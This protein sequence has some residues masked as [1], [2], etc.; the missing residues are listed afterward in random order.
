MEQEIEI[1]IQYGEADIIE[2]LHLFLQFPELR[3]AF[4]E[5]ERKNTAPQMGKYRT[6]SSAHRKSER[7]VY[8]VGKQHSLNCCNL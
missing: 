1:L 4:Q 2:K 6:D 8:R 5:I 3:N 7:Q